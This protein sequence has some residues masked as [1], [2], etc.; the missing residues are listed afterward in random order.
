[1]NKEHNVYRRACAQDAKESEAGKA[2]EAGLRKKGVSN[3]EIARDLKR[4]S[5]L[6]GPP[7]IRAN[8]AW[9][10]GSVL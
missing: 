6:L 7:R 3:G 9:G 10:F 2:Y 5:G 4:R 8:N 1:M